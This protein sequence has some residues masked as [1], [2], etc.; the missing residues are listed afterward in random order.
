[1]RGVSSGCLRAPGASSEQHPWVFLTPRD[2]GRTRVRQAVREMQCL[3][4]TVRKGRRKRDREE[5]GGQICSHPWP[6]WAKL[7][8]S[9]A[10]SRLWMPGPIH[11]KERMQSGWESKCSVR[12]G[13]GPLEGLPALLGGAVPLRWPGDRA[14]TQGPVGQ[15]AGFSILWI[16]WGHSLRRPREDK[17][18][19]A[20]EGPQERP[21]YKDSLPEIT[22]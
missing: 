17:R 5:G 21:P 16:V 4:S 10:E 7:C 1:M 3:N 6:L 8:R 19:G 11:L 9:L 14:E 18:K 12:Y 22:P 2:H 15:Q 20:G 13:A